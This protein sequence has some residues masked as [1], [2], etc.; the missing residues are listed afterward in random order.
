MHFFLLFW[1]FDKI[2]PKFSNFILFCWIDRLILLLFIFFPWKE[3]CM[4]STRY[5]PRRNSF[6]F[7]HTYTRF[8]FFYR[9]HSW[10]AFGNRQLNALSEYMRSTIV[11]W[12]VCVFVSMSMQN[13]DTTRF[14]ASSLSAAKRNFNFFLFYRLFFCSFLHYI[15][16]SSPLYVEFHFVIV[17]YY[18]YKKNTRIYWK[19]Y[20]I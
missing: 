6:S 19:L 18:L 1:D 5:S 20:Y 13:D 15:C 14:C 17:L 10:F 3:I 4:Y 16:F 7:K 8:W 9:C 12:T 11:R 2:I